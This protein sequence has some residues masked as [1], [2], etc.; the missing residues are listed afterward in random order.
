M[1]GELNRRLLLCLAALMVL[2]IV[3]GAIGL[4]RAMENRLTVENRSGQAVSLLTVEVVDGNSRHG[5]I[6]QSLP[7]NGLA[8]ASF[9]VSADGYFHLVGAFTDGTPIEEKSCGYVTNGDFGERVR[10]T[11]KPGGAV[12][13]AD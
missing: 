7:D 3:T 2:L 10:F 13:F 4:F 8:T 11:I 9:S 1:N 5:L 6:S 12:D